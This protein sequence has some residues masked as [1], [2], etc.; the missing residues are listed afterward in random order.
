[1]GRAAS[2]TDQQK[3]SILTLSTELVLEWKSA[4]YIDKTKTVHN[5]I[6]NHNIRKPK[7][8]IT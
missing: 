1:M 5:F 7:Q 6:F 4:E 3:A 2:I 8:E